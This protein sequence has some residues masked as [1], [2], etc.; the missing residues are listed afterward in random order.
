M[1]LLTRRCISA[2]NADQHL[3]PLVPHE[4]CARACREVSAYEGWL[5]I[6]NESRLDPAY[7][8]RRPKPR[9]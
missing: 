1:H 4:V 6:V 8:H 2:T 7:A 5:E 3:A 9:C